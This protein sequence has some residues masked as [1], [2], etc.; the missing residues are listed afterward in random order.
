MHSVHCITKTPFFKASLHNSKRILLTLF[1]IKISLLFL[2]FYPVFIF[3][4]VIL[5]RA[6]VSFFNGIC[7]IWRVAFSQQ[8]ILV[9]GEKHKN[10]TLS[11]F[12][13][14]EIHD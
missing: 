2:C 13:R 1:D 8:K 7:E 11:A 10:K 5:L 6:H 12:S 3:T 9:S 4:D 14:F